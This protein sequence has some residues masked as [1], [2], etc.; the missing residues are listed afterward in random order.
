L[1]DLTDSEILAKVKK[2]DTSAF[3][4]IVQRHEGRVATVIRNMLGNTAEVDDVGQEVFIRLYHSLDKFR[5]EAK[6]STY[7]TRIAVNLS[8]NEIK[9]RKRKKWFSFSKENEKDWEMEDTSSQTNNYENK[10][11]IDKGLQQLKPEHRAV[12]VL[13]MIQGYSVK[14]TAEML[15]LPM[16]TVL[17]RQ[18]RGTQRLK[19][20]LQTKL[21]YRHGE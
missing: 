18:A 19:D 1:K 16:G 2:G 14:E 15:G 11:V 21:S 5:G 4:I 20:I 10:E 13:R 3:S 9:R 17:S 12:V 6:L 8:L 7:I